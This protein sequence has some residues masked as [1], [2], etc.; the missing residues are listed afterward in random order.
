M[1]KKSDVFSLKTANLHR[2]VGRRI[3]GLILLGA[4]LVGVQQAGWLRPLKVVS[5]YTVAPVGSWFAGLGRSSG[6]F[7]GTIG[8]L[9]DL[10]ADNS[11]LES[12]VLDLRRKLSEDAELKVENAALRRQLDFNESSPFKLVTARVV[13]YQ[14]DNFRQF[15]TINRGSNEGIKTGMA[16]TSEGSLVG[17]ISEVSRSSA[18][19][20]LLSDPDFRVAALAQESR[21]SGIVRGLIGGSLFMDKVAQSEALQL[22]DTLVTSGLGGEYPKGLIIGKIETISNPKGAV[23]QS[24][25][26][27][28]SLRLTKLEFVAVVTRSQ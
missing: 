25:R 27:T 17:K 21:A 8:R 10:A 26:I 3:L 2:P 19:V 24:A 1:R 4:V 22:G 15:L 13:A 11:R 9:G 6:N 20:F 16:V 14:P 7:L 18:K 28:P 23:F 5:D 12:E